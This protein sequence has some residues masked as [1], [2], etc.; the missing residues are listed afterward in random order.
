MNYTIGGFDL[1][2]EAN[3]DGRDRSMIF[4]G[5][6]V[7]VQCWGWPQVR[8][9]R[10]CLL[11][12]GRE[13][14]R[15]LKMGRSGWRT[16]V[17][18]CVAVVL[19]SGC[20]GVWA[21]GGPTATP[22]ALPP[23]ATVT[24]S[25]APVP[26]T[27]TFTAVFTRTPTPDSWVPAGEATA[28]WTAVPGNPRWSVWSYRDL[29]FL[30]PVAW[31]SAPSDEDNARVFRAPGGSEQPRL[32][33]RKEPLPSGVGL[34]WFVEG[35]LAAIRD[36]YASSEIVESGAAEIG[37]REAERHVF[38]AS[39]TVTG[40]AEAR[41][42]RGVVFYWVEDGEVASM[43]F[44]INDAEYSRWAGAFEEIVGSVETRR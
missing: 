25:P 23:T 29:I 34:D 36:E 8:L 19:L 3:V 35:D 21:L 43:E 16:M 31:V 32:R 4:A 30:L 42:V 40:T 7:V 41:S 38:A 10:F 26:P 17:G 2:A 39:Q 14:V 27:A 20:G 15:S 6:A 28:T 22:T 37:G 12:R 44:T 11:K 24:P 5:S 33:V 18:M 9:G 1:Q 13:S